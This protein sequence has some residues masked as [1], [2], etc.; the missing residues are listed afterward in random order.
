[1]K[2]CSRCRKT[3]PLEDYALRSASADGR[4]HYCR[5][6]AAEYA[7]MHRPRKR[8]TPPEVADG[9]KW[10]RQ[11]EKV[12][13]ME[14]FPRHAGLP[15]GRQTYCRDCFAERYR[16]KRAALGAVSRPVE[17]PEGFKFCRG[18]AQVKPLDEFG[19][20]LHGTKRATFR[21]NDCMAQRD[22]ER[23][24]A[25]TYGLVEA[26]V[27]QM[28]ERQDGLCA[29][30][31][32]A[33]AIHIDHDHATGAVRGLLCFRCNAALG[34]LGDDPEVL[35]RAARYL[36]TAAKLRVPLEVVWTERLAQVVEYDGSA[37]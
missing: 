17:I 12:R 28:L 25:T 4:Q 21:C 18:C 19:G 11:C 2:T 20:R 35:V 32:S 7:A 23:Y 3:L 37:S 27:Q 33:P 31:R 6:C 24:L 29:I 8:A 22:R 15:D 10:C 26:D 34:Q 36:L 9:L 5:R 13:P 30:C 14:D 16:R 1:M